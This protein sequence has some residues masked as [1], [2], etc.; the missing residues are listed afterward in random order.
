[1]IFPLMFNGLATNGVLSKMS[2]LLSDIIAIKADP[3]ISTYDAFGRLR[4]STPLALFSDRGYRDNPLFWS[5]DING[6]G[7]SIDTS[8]SATT[9]TLDLTV[10]TVSGEYVYRQTRRRFIYEPARSSFISNAVAFPPQDSNRRARVGLF[11]TNDGLYFED[12][13]TDYQFVYRSGV[14]GSPVN[15]TITQ[16]NWNLDSFDGNGPSGININFEDSFVAI[17]DF[18]WHGAGLIRYGFLMKGQPM[19]AHIEELS[20]NT[21]SRFGYIGNPTLPIRLEIENTG[22]ASGS[23]IL[24][25]KASSVASEGNSVE[26]GVVLAEVNSEPL[27]VDDTTLTPLLSIRLSPSFLNS[28]AE[29]IKASILNIDNRPAQVQILYNATLGGGTNW[30]TGE[31]D[32]IQYDE[33]S[34]TVTG[35]T[36]VDGTFVLSEGAISEPVSFNERG[37]GFDINDVPDIITIAARTF[38]K[39]SD[40]VATLQYI[41]KY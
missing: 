5:S 34:T 38:N 8:D 41:A 28:G 13:G 32:I 30:Q 36:R 12:S 19:Y 20:I 22:T 25:W 2:K 21:G 1:M 33:D 27:N 4:T 11:D 6:A 37:L 7:A 18:T 17:I 23:G 39:D 15:N 35:G 16:S 9:S 26:Q 10:G 3:E 40:L 24:D 29:F 14:T 31:T